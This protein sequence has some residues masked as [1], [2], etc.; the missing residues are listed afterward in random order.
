MIYLRSFKVLTH[1]MEEDFFFSFVRTCFTNCY[2]F[3][4][5]PDRLRGLEFDDITILCG[6]NGSG[7]S[8]LLNVIAEKLGLKRE[9][10][11]NKT[12]FFDPYTERCDYDMNIYEEDR[13]AGFMLVSRIITSDDVFNHIIAMREKNGEI[14]KKRDIVF[15]RKYATLRGFNADDPESVNKYI[16][17]C[18]MRRMSASQ[19][20]KQK[21]GEEVRTY[22][23]GENGFRYFVDAIQPGGLYL[24]DEPENSLSPEM[25][26]QLTQYLLSM[27][28]FGNGAIFDSGKDGTTFLFGMGALGITA[29]PDVRR[30]LSESERKILFFK[31]VEAFKIEH[32]KAGRIGKIAAIIGIGQGIKFCYASSVLSSL[33]AVA[34]FSRLE[35]QRGEQTVEQCRFA[36]TRSPRKGGNG[37]VFDIGDAFFKL[38][39]G[40]SNANAKNL[41]S[42]ATVDVGKLGGII[43]S[44]LA[45]GNHNN[46]FDAVVLGNG[47]ELI[48]RF[49]HGV[50]SS[51]GKRYKQKVKVRHRRTDQRILALENLIDCHTRAILGTFDVAVLILGI[52]GVIVSHF[53]HVANQQRAA[54]VQASASATGYGTSVQWHRLARSITKQTHCKQSAVAFDDSSTPLIHSF[55]SFI[56]FLVKYKS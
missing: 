8:T 41:K 33:D 54:T 36:N 56:R 18:D 51:G 53:Y 45:L 55:F 39:N 35:L 12:Y 34:D 5:F 2:P 28:R 4:F 29:L 1:S 31:K 21:I 15:N 38:R 6:S 50:G 47:N 32:G 49:E 23:N 11:Y 14:D 37:A 20:V 19:Y 25:Q 27:A 22:S 30:E 42:C 16:D 46:G 40:K 48:H 44:K 3:R 26:L 7:K 52:C 9:T 10:P 17:Y 24:L 13:I 43:G